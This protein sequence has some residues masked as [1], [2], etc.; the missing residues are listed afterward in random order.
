VPETLLRHSRL[1]AAL[2]FLPIAGP[3]PRCS[4]APLHADVA[5]HADTPPQA[6]A[7]LHASDT[8]GNSLVRM[9]NISVDGAR[10]EIRIRT[11]LAIRHG[12]LEF[13]LVSDM[14]R[15]YESALK[16]DSAK[17]SDLHA[18]LLLLGLKPMESGEFG[19]AIKTDMPLE[20]FL[21]I[22]PRSA[23]RLGI[24]RKGT[25]YGIDRLIKSREKKEFT[26]IWAF[27]GSFFARDGR[28]GADLTQTYISV[29]P[30][31]SAVINLFSTH[32]NPYKGD[33]GFRMHGQQPWQAGDTLDLV[34]KPYI[35]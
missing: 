11:R 21:R 5:L 23:M 35:P 7:A 22:F 14:G 33:F 20:A 28:Y 17:P 1:I 29:W 2:L 9:G 26:N 18:A 6:D 19:N 27:T 13:L 30:D 25:P 31:E 12:I 24:E 3:A 4:D 8:S 15:T 10:K 32:G 34:I 16:I